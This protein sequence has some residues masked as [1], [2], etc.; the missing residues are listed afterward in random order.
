MIRKMETKSCW[1]RWSS[2]YHFPKSSVTVT[3][4]LVDELPLEVSGAR[5]SLW[6]SNG[7]LLNTP[8]QIQFAL[9]LYF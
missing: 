5:C 3:N 2:S 4:K 7:D 6:T 1:C 8:R 9:K